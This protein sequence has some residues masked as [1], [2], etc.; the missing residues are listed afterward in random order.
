MI[1][2]YFEDS[3][4]INTNHNTM[5]KLLF[6]TAALM[7]M[8]SCNGKNA[9]SENPSDSGSV[10]DTTSLTIADDST[11][12]QTVADSATQEESLGLDSTKIAKEEK[13]DKD[14][15]DKK[16]NAPSPNAK[17]IDKYLNGYMKDA[18]QYKQAVNYGM[19]G[20]ELAELGAYGRKAQ[21]R[22]KKYENEMTSEQKEKFKKANKMFGF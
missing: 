3:K 1:F 18:K 11:K 22:L 12:N 17:L 19:M 7:L 5:K 21:K 9:T 8:I 4:I 16:D 13:E 15:N 10:N 14:K 2:L 6:G 20:A